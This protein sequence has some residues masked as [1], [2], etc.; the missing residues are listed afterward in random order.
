MALSFPFDRL[1]GPGNE[2]L[3]PVAPVRPIESPLKPIYEAR[4]LAAMAKQ[5]EADTKLKQAL[6]RAQVLREQPLYA[7]GEGPLGV[8]IG[9]G[10]GG[11]APAIGSMVAGILA[12]KAH[13]K[14]GEASA[15]ALGELGPSTQSL[16]E[17]FIQGSPGGLYGSGYGFP[18]PARPV[19]QGTPLSLPLSF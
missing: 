19:P 11:W 9:Q 16:A 17:N 4:T 8:T 1:A 15:A 3:P 6:L 18:Q 7:Q 12:K 5:R 13:E 2:A 10:P 14:A